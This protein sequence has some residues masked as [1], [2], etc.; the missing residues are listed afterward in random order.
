[1]P[2]ATA[3][4]LPSRVLTAWAATH[5]SASGSPGWKNDQ[6]ALHRYSRTWMKSQT[7]WAVTCRRAASAVVAS[8]WV[9]VPS[10]RGVQG[11][12]GGG[13]RRSGSAEPAG[14]T[15]ERES[16]GEGKRGSLWGGPVN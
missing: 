4:A 11:R 16:G 8:I 10:T 6:A 12:G 9:A 1:M 5:C 7:M 15:G 3:A 13:A 14:G 2:A